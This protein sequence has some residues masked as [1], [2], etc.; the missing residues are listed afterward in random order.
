MAYGTNKHRPSARPLSPVSA[1]SSASLVPPPWNDADSTANMANLSSFSSWDS[2]YNSP[3]PNSLQIED[4][5][6]VIADGS[7]R[8]IT[9]S[10]RDDRESSDL[11]IPTT[12]PREPSEETTFNDLAFTNEQRYLAAYWTWV[13][14]QYPIVHKPTF[15][16]DR[17]T[18]LLRASMLALGA[19]MLQSRTDI[20]NA[21]TIHERCVKV[22]KR[23]SVEGT[24]TFRICDMQAIVLTEV[25]TIFKA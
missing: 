10:E 22:L 14:P 12:A 15:D 20:E 11:I 7:V 24:H 25:Y 6:Q 8:M 3:G 1:S 19:C 16:L 9:A 23:R 5:G 18:P 13:Y 17:T 4:H 2:C 21:S